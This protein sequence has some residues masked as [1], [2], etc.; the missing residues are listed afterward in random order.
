MATAMSIS[1]TSTCW[2]RPSRS[3]ASNASRIALQADIPVARS[4][5]G[6]PVRTGCPSGKPFSDMKPLSACVIGSNPGRARTARPPIGGDRAIDQARIGRSDRGIVKIKFLHHPAGEI[7]DH[8]IRLGN[9][10]AGHLQRL[11]SGKVERDA[12]LVAVEAE[13][14]G[15]LAADFSV[16]EVPRVVAAVGVFDLDDLGTEVGQ[17]LRAGGPGHDAGE[18]HH[19]QSVESRR[20]TLLAW[21]AIPANAVRRS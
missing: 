7:L 12:P 10:L 18:I 1:A 20:H 6:G 4:T 17:R 14:G 11:R 9:E 15:A 13:I 8:H 2:P 3:R 19:Q 5:I 21:H 16:L